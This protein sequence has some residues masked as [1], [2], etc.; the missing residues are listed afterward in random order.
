MAHAVDV[1]QERL[2]KDLIDGVNQ[3]DTTCLNRTRTKERG[4]LPDTGSELCHFRADMVT[5]V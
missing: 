5:P 3:F 4:I 2:H 1:A